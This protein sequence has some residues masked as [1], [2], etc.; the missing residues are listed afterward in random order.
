MPEPS[1]F[2]RLTLIDAANLLTY[3][4]HAEFDN[5]MLRLS[6]ESYMSSVQGLSK[7]NKVNQLIRYATEHPEHQTDLGVGLW[8]ALVERAA[9]LAHPDRNIGFMRALERDGYVLTGEGTLRRTLPPEA[10]LPRADDEVHALL[11]EL[12]M[13]TAKGHLDQAIDNHARGQWAAANAQVRTFLQELFDEIAVR[14]EPKNAAGT[15]AGE[16]R[17]QLLANRQPSFLPELLGESGKQGKNF[18]N[19]V[20]KRLHGQGSHPGLSDEEDCTFR[21]HLVLIVAQHYLRRAQSFLS[22]P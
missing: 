21:L 9:S 18:I 22:T 12:R 8:V 2:S 3:L 14:L 7:Q 17:R 16:N 4:D 11:D 1:R 20:F 15:Q 13:D 5:L 19:G 6:V 10:D